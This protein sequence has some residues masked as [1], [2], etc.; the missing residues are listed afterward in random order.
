MQDFYLVDEV[1]LVVLDMLEP[2]I[3]TVSVDDFG[4]LFADDPVDMAT[5]FEQVI[6]IQ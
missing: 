3:R 4:R 5:L 2:A 1:P 6:L